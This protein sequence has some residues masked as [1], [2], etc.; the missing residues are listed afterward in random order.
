MSPALTRTE[1]LQEIQHLY[2]LRGYTDNEL[3]DRLGVNR[4]TIY[5][6]RIELEGKVPIYQDDEGRYRIDRSTY[7]SDLRVNLTEALSLYLAARRAAQQTRLAHQHVASAIEKLSVAL[8]QP[9]TE[10]LVRVADVILSQRKAP[11]R[12]AV[13][14]TVAKAWAET[15]RLKLDYCAL[16]DGMTRT[17]RFEPYL[18]EPSPWSDGVYL[19]GYSDLAQQVLTLKL[20][21]IVKAELL[22]PFEPSVDFDEGALLRHAWG[23]WGGE[24]TTETVV[25]RFTPGPATRR[26]KESIWHPL[27]SV[28]DL[29]DG[30]CRWEAPIAEWQ[31][32]LPWIRGWG[33]EVEVLA[34]PILRA[35]L[36]NESRGLAEQ[37][38]W[39]IHGRNCAVTT[40]DES[41]GGFLGE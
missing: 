39:R 26:L 37:Y 41:F 32:M 33:A 7:I 25:L 9:M 21:R 8:Y 17:H 14:A 19:I 10:R 12:T 6:D 15:R 38:G 36:I 27:E 13:F 34:P 23:I 40:R 22:G 28:T 20:D 4:T 11:A 3:A 2:L 1:R 29:D 31:E 24:E 35:T 18:L 30:G 5:R 16:R